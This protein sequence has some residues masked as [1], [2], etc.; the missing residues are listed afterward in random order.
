MLKNPDSRTHKYAKVE[1]KSPVIYYSIHLGHQTWNASPCDPGLRLEFGFIC[2]SPGNAVALEAMPMPP[3]L[4]IPPIIII[5][6]GGW[7][8]CIGGDRIRFDGGGSGGRWRG[9][10]G[11]T[12]PRPGGNCAVAAAAAAEAASS[13]CRLRSSSSAAAA[14]AT[15]TF[16]PG[17]GLV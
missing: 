13:T 7:E 4:F 16:S 6:G 11:P 15:L 12:W 10:P 5:D 3:L 1:R 17:L 14:L 2:P 9:A 8:N